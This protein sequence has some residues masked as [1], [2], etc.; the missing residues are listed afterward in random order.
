MLKCTI[1]CSSAKS[2]YLLGKDLLGKDLLGK[3]LHSH[4]TSLMAWLM[5]LHRMMV[6]TLA[7]CGSRGMGLQGRGQI[8]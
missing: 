8:E 2:R 5:L 1:V 3:D 6:H 4:H 7:E